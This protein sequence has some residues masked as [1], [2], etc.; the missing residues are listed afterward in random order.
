LLEK[1]AIELVKQYRQEGEENIVVIPEL[2]K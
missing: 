2:E 1:E